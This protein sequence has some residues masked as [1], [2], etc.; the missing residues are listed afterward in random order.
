MNKIA[1]IT[2]KIK[3][4]NQDINQMHSLREISG[5]IPAEGIEKFA[6]ILLIIWNLSPLLTML[7]MTLLGPNTD[8]FAQMTYLLSKNL[9]WFT[10]LQQ[11]GLIGCLLGILVLVKSIFNARAARIR[12]SDYLT[13]H[14]FP[15][16]LFLMLIWSVFSF[17]LSSDMNLSFHGTIFRMEGLLAYICYAGIFICAFQIKKEWFVYGLLN[18]FT[19][20]AALLSILSIV[21]IKLVNQW[22]DLTA[23][24]SIFNNENHYAYYLCLALMASLHLLLREKNQVHQLLYRFVSFGLICT[25]LVLNHSFGPYL[26]VLAG[27][28]FTIIFVFKSQK[29][30]KI[31]LLLAVGLFVAISLI[32]NL[33]FNYLFSDFG[34]LLSDSRNI[35]TGSADAA[36]AGS[37]RWFLWSNGLRFIAERPFFGY[38]PDNLGAVY[39]AAGT[40]IDRPHN[41]LI[42]FAASLGLPALI[43]YL[44]ALISLLISF[45]KKRWL[46]TLTGIGFF[47]MIAAYLF[48][49][50][51]GNTMFY[52]TP[53]FLILL[54]LSGSLVKIKASDRD[55]YPEQQPLSKNRNDR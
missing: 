39:L 16:F 36:N 17:L 27:L 47:A 2:A 3:K 21:N 33:F 13:S 52:T 30:K 14:A 5:Y 45:I 29:N 50:L 22:F 35:L 40:V 55:L 12:F 26:A 28:V 31:R 44:S 10:M 7:R 19:A 41:E 38:G 8:Q 43:F 23:G 18:C 51:L 15:I 53:F 11:I 24:T 48:S 4:I 49:S 32:I 34:L 1:I 9:F 6:F 46:T 25:A 42:Q 37:Y 54:G 20:V